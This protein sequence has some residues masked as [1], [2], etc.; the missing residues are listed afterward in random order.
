MKNKILFITLV[1]IFN[2]TLRMSAQNNQVDIYLDGVLNSTSWSV[3]N[4]GTFPALAANS[5]NFMTTHVAD[6]SG[7]IAID[8]LK[9]YDASGTLILYNTMGSESEIENSA[10]GINGSYNGFGRIFSS[11]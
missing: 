10:V 3:L 5:L 6:L 9:I 8:E 4:A 7:E 2:S 1:A 11:G